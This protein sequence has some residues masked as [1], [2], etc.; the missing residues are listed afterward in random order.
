MEKFPNLKIYVEKIIWTNNSKKIVLLGFAFKPNTNDVRESSA[1]Y[2]TKSLIDN[3]AEVIIHDPIVS[4]EDIEKVLNKSSESVGSWSFKENLFESLKDAD[5]VI[6]LTQWEDYFNLDWEK[7]FSL[8]RKPAWIFDTRS[9]LDKKSLIKLG[10]N[11]WG[12]GD[13][14]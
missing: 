12:L 9:I 8:M 3:G 11:F 14:K 7:I 2:I 1:I 5:A 10:F 13:G 6:L 4:S